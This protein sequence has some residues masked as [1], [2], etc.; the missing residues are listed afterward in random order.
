M[1]SVDIADF[2]QIF[3]HMKQIIHPSKS[4][5]YI[6]NKKKNKKKQRYYQ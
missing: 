6:K 2:Y 5:S 3:L 1:F 4:Q